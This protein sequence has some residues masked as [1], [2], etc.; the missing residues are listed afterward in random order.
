MDKGK[1]SSLWSINGWDDLFLTDI[2]EGNGMTP[3]MFAYELQIFFVPDLVS[4]WVQVPE[5]NIR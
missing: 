3:R 4:M 5:F 2:T 1:L